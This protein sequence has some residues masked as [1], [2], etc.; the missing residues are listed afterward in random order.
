MEP[1]FT[2][3][4]KESRSVTLHTPISITVRIRDLEY[5]ILQEI[6]RAVLAAIPSETEF[7]IQDADWDESDSVKISGIVTYPGTYTHTPACGLNP[8]ETCITPDDNSV[9]DIFAFY[10]NL[11]NYIKTNAG[12]NSVWQNAIHN[13]LSVSYETGDSEIEM[14][15]D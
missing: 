11:Q 9:L 7:Q 12:G 2:Y 6:Q 14:D 10:E 1:N 3:D 8:P 15:W 13:A 5:L 4:R